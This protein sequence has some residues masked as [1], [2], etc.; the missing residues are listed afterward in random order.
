MVQR[1]AGASLLGLLAFAALAAEDWQP[2]ALVRYPDRVL[3]TDMQR[4][5][6]RL[7][8]GGERGRILYSDDH[9]QH[10]QLA[11]TPG[12]PTLTRLVAGPGTTAYALGHLGTLW[13]STDRGSHW[14]ALTL[15]F[16]GE[17]EALL[18]LWQ[19]DDQMIV[20][21][22]YGSY[23]ESADG[24]KN[25]RQRRPF[26]DDFDWHINTIVR[27]PTGALLVLGEAGFMARSLDH[28]RSWTPLA[29]PYEGSWF[30]A[31]ASAS[32]RLFIYGMRGH[33]F[34]SGDD[35]QRWQPID[36]GGTR[37]S[38]QGGGVLADG[39][40]VLVGN[41]GFIALSDDDGQRFQRQQTNQRKTLAALVLAGDGQLW[42][43]GMAGVR[44]V[45]IQ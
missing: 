35:G 27:S 38:L 14:Q 7:V 9:G 28:G 26:G 3:L 39:R 32:G 40:I 29:S 15:P 11:H 13:R 4:W 30:G 44:P 2:E 1:L 43:A 36:L 33:A 34:V 6:D 22:A 45:P 17:P 42:S 24:G 25:F 20:V 10:W 18:D 5:G 12:Y 21:G 23:F 31:F 8:A 19:R 16:E 37:N 41:E